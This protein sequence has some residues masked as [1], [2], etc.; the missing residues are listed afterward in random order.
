MKNKIQ[1][2]I[3]ALALI[4]MVSY[5][6][7]AQVTSQKIGN[8]PTSI[9]PNAVLEMESA[10]K[11][12]LFPRVTLTS[13]TDVVTVNSPTDGLTV[14]NTATAGT[15][16][17]NVSFGYYYWSA[18]ASKWVKLA[19][20]TP[21]IE[22]AKTVYVNAAS[23]ST[24]TI[25]DETNPAV[26]N[27]NTL[28]AAVANLY[29]GND[30]ST[31]T[32]DNA[33]TT[34]KTYAVAPST[35]FYLAN[36]TND[37]G[38]NKTGK[39]WRTGN[40]GIGTNNPT[41]TLDVIGGAS[42][43]NTAGG[44]GTGYGVEINTDSNAPRIDW[45][46]NGAYIGQFSSNATDFNL[47][48]SLSN[49]GNIRFW[50]REANTGVE[51]LTILNNGNIGI[52]NANPVSSLANTSS[53]IQGSNVTGAINGGLN[54]SSPGIGFSGSFYSQPTNG[55][56][57]QVKIAGNTSANNAFE[58]STGTQ[59][60]IATPLFN[61]LG[62]GRVGIGTASPA[63]TLHIQ[64]PLPATANVNANAQVL[65]LSRPTTTNI[66]WDNI[67]QF[68]LGSYSTAIAAQSRLDLA[69]TNGLDAATFTNVMTWQANG[70]VGINNTAPSAPLVIQ[71]VVGTGALK[72]IAP[73]VAAGDNWW[74][75]FGHGSLSTD[76]NDRAR[77]GVDIAGGGPGRL[78]FTTG[79]T[80]TQTRAMFIDENQRVGIGTSSPASKLDVSTG[81]TT[82]N[83]IVN[84][85]GS[86]NDYLQFNVQNTSTGT[87]AQSGY[88]AT[89]DNGSATSGFAWVGINNSNFNFPTS[90]NIGGA[91]DV[92]FIGSGQDL[93]VAN[94]NNTKSIIFS[95]GRAT[96]PFFSEQMRILNNGN[97]GIGTSSPTSRLE[98]DGA[99]T[100]KNAFNAASGTTID[101]SK[102][103][104][105]YTTSNPTAFTLQNI[106]DGGTY[107]LAV[108]GTSSATATFSC[109]GFTF[110]SPNNG[111]TIAGKETI[112]TFIVMGTKVYVYMTAGIN[113]L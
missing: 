70:N 30:G 94:A 64:N 16:P 18:T 19:V 56:G 24:A 14:F 98:V 33:N 101:F 1:Y 86:I 61:V 111:A 36:T 108:Q 47:K 104:L 28:K 9:S 31:W 71:G 97:V 91:N 65:R 45:V 20:E 88:S 68:N 67:A 35:P 51:R 83:S 62:N 75:G 92:S 48:N 107:T 34:Y 96:T 44:S 4:F 81:V 69:L 6:A 60:G 41:N 90:Y 59:I 84:A 5:T 32:Y 53:Q 106:K 3:S 42:I 102:S 13:I 79:S 74:M 52:N 103:N 63:T 89:A 27:N 15:S 80:G 87:Q 54:W 73:S 112:Y 78:F 93:Y 55:N 7:N 40:L 25:F 50:T 23:P 57:L 43:R 105:A 17:N 21:P 38:S 2:I 8:N 77:I 99:A 49:T 66:K 39:I 100:N 10:T 113:D 22:F 85:T 11:G 29:I 46:S 109:S 76:A 26:T 82:A 12:V 95:T 37:A 58:V 110:K 72:L